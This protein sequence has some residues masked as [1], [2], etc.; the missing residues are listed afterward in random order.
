MK[1]MEC[2]ACGSKELVE[3]GD[4]VQCVYCQSRFAVEN[5]SV[6][7]RGPAEIAPQQ[8]EFD[9]VLTNV[10]RKKMALTK[11]VME[12]TGLGMRDAVQLVQAQPAVILRGTD[13]ARARAA[14]STLEGLGATVEIR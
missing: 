6:A 4:Y 7:S 9:V 13:L 1:L 8:A 5:A 14:K 3:Y 10:G 12:L 11:A 2:T